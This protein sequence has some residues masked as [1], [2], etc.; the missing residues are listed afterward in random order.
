MKNKQIFIVVL[1]GVLAGNIFAEGNMP[2][3]VINTLR[4]GY[5]DNVYRTSQNP[6]ESAYVEDI[7]D[8]S[9]RAALSDRTDLIFKSRFNYRSDKEMVFHPNLY[10]VLTHSVSPRLMLQLSDKFTSGNKTSSTREG[11]Y[12]YY[13]NTLS[14]SPSYV[15]TPKDRLSVPLSYQIKRNENKIDAEDAD[16]ISAGVSWKRELSPQRTWAALNL[17]QVMVDYVNRDSKADYTQ[18]TAELSHTFNPQW[19]GVVEGGVTFSQTD[20]SY[21][22]PGTNINVNVKS[23]E[24][25]PYFRAGLT[26][27]PSQRTRLT[28]DVYQ[29]FRDS[30]SALYAGENARALA[31]GAQHDFTAKIMGKLTTRFVETDRDQKNN[32]TGGGTTTE[33]YFDI[34]LRFQYK[35]NHSNFIE[36]GV[37]HKEKAYDTGNRDWDQNMA[38]I[39]WRVEL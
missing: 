24:V 8:L 3:S 15:L 21:T 32:E 36:F 37:R 9:F 13:Y 2:F 7:V 22:I 16:I 1:I 10:A 28:A 29:K 18:I 35:L 30:N 39:G 38:D 5:D 26:Y 20:F 31:F 17:S 4:V 27:S 11:R 12:E 25:N 19:Q 23:D 33:D 6:Q 34:G 14:F